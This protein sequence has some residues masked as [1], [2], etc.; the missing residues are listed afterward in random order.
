MGLLPTRRIGPC[1]KAR[2]LLFLKKKKQKDFYLLGAAAGVAPSWNTALAV[3][4]MVAFAPGMPRCGL[5]EDETFS[6]T[7]WQ[8]PGTD[9]CSTLHS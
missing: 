2:I 7:M 6:C 1:S 3:A 8:S 5:T 4:D 9:C